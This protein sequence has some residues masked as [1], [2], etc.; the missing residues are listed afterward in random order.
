MSGDLRGVGVTLLAFSLT[1]ETV[2]T[3]TTATCVGDV[4]VDPTQTPDHA[5]QLVPSG[6]IAITS[7]LSV[8]CKTR[9]NMKP[10]LGSRRSG[11]VR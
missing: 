7:S 9:G 1:V 10:V 8:V 11:L 2:Q 6:N 3:Q 4:E 5:T